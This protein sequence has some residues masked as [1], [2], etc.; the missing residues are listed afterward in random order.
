MGNANV[1][2]SSGNRVS[3]AEDIDGQT[4]GSFEGAKLKDRDRRISNVKDHGRRKSILKKDRRSFGPKHSTALLDLHEQIDTALS[5]PERAQALFTRAFEL[6]MQELVE[7][8]TEPHGAKRAKNFERHDT[9]FLEKFNK[10]LAK[11]DSPFEAMCQPSVK[12]PSERDA[13]RQKI[14]V[15]LQDEVERLKAVCQVLEE[16][17]AT[18]GNV[19][20]RLASAREGNGE[21]LSEQQRETLARLQKQLYGHSQRVV[22]PQIDLAVVDRL[23]KMQQ[24]M[25]EAYAHFV[26]SAQTTL[27]ART[28]AKRSAADAHPAAA[29][30]STL[31]G[32]LPIEE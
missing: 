7:A 18:L 28:Q 27:H 15:D 30:M 31:I 20:K 13:R 5:P 4:A 1:S 10:E 25:Q 19:N 16:Q 6:S 21:E 8:A 11:G 26:S 9:K 3:I 12:R 14:I 32:E 23:T 29:D 17:K 2:N 24:H 22:A